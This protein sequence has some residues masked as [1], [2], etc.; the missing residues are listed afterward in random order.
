M[1]LILLDDP[2]FS[3]NPIHTTPS[4]YK[5][6][7]IFDQK[8]ENKRCAKFHMTNPVTKIYLS[9]RRIQWY[10]GLLCGNHCIPFNFNSPLLL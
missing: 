2:T 1:T 5:K 7:G 4:V 3:V 10:T 8:T 6:R 9:N